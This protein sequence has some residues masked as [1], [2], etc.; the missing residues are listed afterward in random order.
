MNLTLRTLKGK[1]HLYK[2]INEISTIKFVKSL[3]AK[4][5]GHSVRRL[6]LCDSGKNWKIQ[7]QLN[8]TA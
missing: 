2:N 3:Y 7:K 4:K 8:G 5:S 6:R 1:R